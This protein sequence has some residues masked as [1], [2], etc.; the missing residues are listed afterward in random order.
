MKPHTPAAPPDP[1]GKLFLVI[2]WQ[3]FCDL[4][5]NEKFSVDG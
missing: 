4:L 5:T 3:F 1:Q 2:Y